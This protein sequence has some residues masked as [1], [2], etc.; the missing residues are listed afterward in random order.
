MQDHNSTQN[1]ENKPVLTQYLTI[2]KLKLQWMHFTARNN[3]ILFLH[4]FKS[5]VTLPITPH[6]CSM[7]HMY[8]LFEYSS[9]LSRKYAK[10]NIKITYLT[11]H[12]IIIVNNVNNREARRTERMLFPH[13]I[14][15]HISHIY[16][17]CIKVTSVCVISLKI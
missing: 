16:R 12:F 6:M 7:P 2:L 17:Y 13:V 5:K 8:E 9:I 3:I 10:Y 4:Y 11:Q 14:G 1:R 15:L